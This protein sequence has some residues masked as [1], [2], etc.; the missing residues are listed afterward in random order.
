MKMAARDCWAVGYF[1][2]SA[3]VIKVSKVATVVCRGRGRRDCWWASR[4]HLSVLQKS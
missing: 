1:D 2:V 4:L 3:V